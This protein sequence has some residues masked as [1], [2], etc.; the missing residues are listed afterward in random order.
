MRFGESGGLEAHI[1]FYVR[2]RGFYVRFKSFYV[3]SP[4]FYVRFSNFYVHSR[5]VPKNNSP[6]RSGGHKLII[7][8]QAEAPF[9]G[10][11]TSGTDHT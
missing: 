6:R 1:G 7:P 11:S 10:P 3:R 2:S 8:S 5:G 4:A 9:S